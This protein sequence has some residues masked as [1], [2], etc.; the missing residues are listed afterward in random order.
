MLYVC[1]TTFFQQKTLTT[2]LFGSSGE[3]KLKSVS[4][5]AK[6]DYL[7]ERVTVHYSFQTCT[8]LLQF[9]I[10]ALGA[11]IGQNHFWTVSLHLRYH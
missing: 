7:L 5:A 1:S 11:E 6:P 8:L 4:I 9:R 2:C 10:W 3:K